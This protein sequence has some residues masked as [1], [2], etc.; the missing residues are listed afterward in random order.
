MKRLGTNLLYALA[1]GYILFVFSERLFWTVWRPND[2]LL[3]LT[4]T[5]LAYSVVAYLFLA[6]VA[7]SRARMTSGRSSWPVHSTDGSWKGA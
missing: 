1:T 3:D 7:W 4:I 2:Q 5:W 6:A